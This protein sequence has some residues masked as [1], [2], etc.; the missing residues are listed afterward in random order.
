M[1]SFQAIG[2]ISSIKYQQD[3]CLVFVDE[4]KKGFRKKDGTIVADRYM[5]W[6]CIFKKGLVK[7][8]NDH[9]SNGMLVEV[10]GEVFP[11]A[12]EHDTTVDGYSVIG[13]TINMASFPRASARQEAAMIKDSQL[14]VNDVPDMEEYNK[15][16]F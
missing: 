16:D 15:P 9:F 2:F 13:Q 8:I 6:K 4:F 5:Q 3:F 7:Y 12:V 11:Y 10:K 1:A 14:H